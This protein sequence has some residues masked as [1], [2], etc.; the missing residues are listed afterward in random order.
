MYWIGIYDYIYDYIYVLDVIII[1]CSVIPML[2]RFGRYVWVNSS[3]GWAFF[4]GSAHLSQLVSHWIWRSI[5]WKSIGD[6]MRCD[7]ETQLLWCPAYH[8]PHSIHLPVWQWVPLVSSNFSTISAS[9]VFFSLQS[10]F[11]LSLHRGCLSCACG[12]IANRKNLVIIANHRTP[13]VHAATAGNTW[14]ATTRD[15][16][17]VRFSPLQDERT[18]EAWR[19]VW[20][21]RPNTVTGCPRSMSNDP[22]IIQFCSWQ[23][24]SSSTNWS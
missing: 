13:S 7:L 22:K 21:C 1:L 11:H 10:E 17:A 16:C 15:R 9:E 8:L 18:G 12:R 4:C 2:E 5:R 14:V 23:I 24:L 3:H 20:I 6:V 19:S